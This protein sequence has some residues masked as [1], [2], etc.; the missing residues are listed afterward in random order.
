MP[1]EEHPTGETEVK[2]KAPSNRG[3]RHENIPSREE[4]IGPPVR[5]NES[6]HHRIGR[7][8]IKNDQE[9]VRLGSSAAIN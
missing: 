8:R 3:D 5:R 6:G 1:T 7:R 9:K 2:K 4:K